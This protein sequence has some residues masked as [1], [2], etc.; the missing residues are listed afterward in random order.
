MGEPDQ[1]I[2]TKEAVED[3]GREN[4]AKKSRQKGIWY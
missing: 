4:N 3:D 2:V 1:Q